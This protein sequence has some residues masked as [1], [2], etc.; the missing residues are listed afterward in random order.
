MRMV[1]VAVLAM[2]I[3]VRRY[4]PV[5]GI[6]HH[7]ARRRVAL[8]CVRSVRRVC[9]LLVSTI[10]LSRSEVTWKLHFRWWMEGCVPTENRA[11]KV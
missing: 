2:A 10:I 1:H 5:R 8:S 9:I 4:H 11:F 3:A 6:A 7:C